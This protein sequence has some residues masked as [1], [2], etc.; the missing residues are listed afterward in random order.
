[1]KHKYS[2]YQHS[3]IIITSDMPCH[4]CQKT[5]LNKK[6]LHCKSKIRDN[7]FLLRFYRKMLSLLF[8]LILDC[9]LNVHEVNC[10]EQVMSCLNFKTMP[11]QLS[12]SA[13]SKASID[14]LTFQQQQQSQFST[15]QQSHQQQQDENN[16]SFF[17]NK[18]NNNSYSNRPRSMDITKYFQV[19]FHSKYLCL[20]DYKRT[21]VCN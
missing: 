3:F 10:K 19:N 12:L 9:L 17:L 8:Y 7:L 4:I 11:K 2:S 20:A 21:S 16:G 15:N 1:M 5:L 14:L 18:T 13:S 6:A